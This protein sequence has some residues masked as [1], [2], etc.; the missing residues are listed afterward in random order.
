M[1]RIA[2]LEPTVNGFI[3]MLIAKIT[4]YDERETAKGKYVNPNFMAIAFGS[5]DERLTKKFKKAGLLD[6]NDPKV[7]KVLKK[8]IP[9][10]ITIPRVINPV[11]KAIDAYI[12]SG[13]LPKYPVTSRVRGRRANEFR[14][15]ESRI[16]RL[17]RQS[18]TMSKKDRAR[19]DELQILEDQDRLNSKQKRASMSVRDSSKKVMKALAE[20]DR[21]MSQ[22]DNSLHSMPSFTSD[23]RYYQQLAKR[24]YQLR[25]NISTIKGEVEH[26]KGAY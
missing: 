10:A 7:L 12:D 16:A 19:L 23:D 26:I 4:Q 8:L 18:H 21:A 6:S 1:R 2:N 24:W 13:K 15:L 17:E 20:L 22:M 3:T 25:K 9:T 5:V 11:I 14:S